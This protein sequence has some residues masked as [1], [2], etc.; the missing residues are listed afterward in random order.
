MQIWFLNVKIKINYQ[1]LQSSK[2]SLMIK[3]IQSNS[4]LSLGFGDRHF[5][6]IKFKILKI[7]QSPNV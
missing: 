3:A 4:G 2:H 5:D 1:I 7:W 6:M